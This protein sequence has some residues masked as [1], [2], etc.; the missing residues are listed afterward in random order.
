MPNTITLAQIK[1]DL[2]Q[3]LPF[4]GSHPIG[5][6][7]IIGAMEVRRMEALPLAAYLQFWALWLTDADRAQLEAVFD[8]AQDRQ[9]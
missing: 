6:E 5:L 9:A 8:V 3:C 7:Y 1:A 4:D 2:M